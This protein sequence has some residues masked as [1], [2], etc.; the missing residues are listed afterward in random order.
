VTYNDHIRAP[1]LAVLVSIYMAIGNVYLF[2]LLQEYALTICNDMD[3]ARV[4]YA[5]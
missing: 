4:Y 5:K 1:D 2:I 3:G